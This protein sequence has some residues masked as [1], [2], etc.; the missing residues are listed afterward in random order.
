MA[1]W[2]MTPLD[3]RAPGPD[4]WPAEAGCFS[5]HVLRVGKNEEKRG[6]GKQHPPSQTNKAAL[7]ETGTLSLSERRQESSSTEKS[8][9]FFPLEGHGS[10]CPSWKSGP[11]VFRPPPLAS[12]LGQKPLRSPN[13]PGAPLHVRAVPRDWLGP[14]KRSRNDGC[15]W[16]ARA[17]KSPWPIP[18]A[19]FPGHWDCGSRMF[20]MAWLQDGASVRLRP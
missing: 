7:H 6:R 9:F 8:S 2:G 17:V 11:R 15:R 20:R 19:L 1:S 16:Q 4:G 18:Q 3:P 14:V 13:T 12:V 10:L 5:S